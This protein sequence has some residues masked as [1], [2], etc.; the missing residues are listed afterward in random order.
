MDEFYSFFKV[1]VKGD[2]KS[3]ALMPTR[4]ILGYVCATHSHPALTACTLT[5]MSLTHCTL[6]PTSL[7]LIALE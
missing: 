6:T 4:S 3:A 1:C 7:S 2:G 5:P